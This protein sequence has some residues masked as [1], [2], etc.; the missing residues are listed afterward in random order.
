MFLVYYYD[1]KVSLIPHGFS[2]AFVCHGAEL[3]VLQPHV[4]VGGA[5]SVCSVCFTDM[6]TEACVVCVLQDLCFCGQGL[7]GVLEACV[8]FSSSLSVTRFTHHTHL[9]FQSS[10][11]SFLSPVIKTRILQNLNQDKMHKEREGLSALKY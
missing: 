2:V 3:C 4:C 8:C 7:C 5:S 1:Y 11:C 9:S 10:H 6:R